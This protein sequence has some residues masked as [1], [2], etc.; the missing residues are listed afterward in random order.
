MVGPILFLVYINYLPLNAECDVR[1]FAVDT[2]VHTNTNNDRQLQMDL[3][4]LEQWE[5]DWDMHFNPFK[6]EVIRFSRKKKPAVQRVYTLHDENIPHAS[7]I[8]Y[9]GVKIQSD[10]QWNAHIDYTISKAS[11]TLG[12]IKRTIPPRSTTH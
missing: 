12:F 5:A 2:I 6:C 7:T 1:L 3:N 11:S 10:L 4:S 9:L 8:Q